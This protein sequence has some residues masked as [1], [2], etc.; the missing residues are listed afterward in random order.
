MNAILKDF[1][2]RVLANAIE[3]NMIAHSADLARS[4]LVELHRGDRLI[5]SI[6]T[7]N[8]PRFNRIL[9]A[10]FPQGDLEG[11]ITAALAPFRWRGYAGIWHTGPSTQPANLGERLEAYGLRLAAREPGMAADLQALP[12]RSKP[13]PGLVV[14]KIDG[15]DGL[16]DW[17]RI[18]AAAFGLPAE[19]VEA[20]F[21]VE[22]TLEA[23]PVPRRML[24]LGRL[25]G[26]TVAC[27]A[28]FVDSSVAGL[29]S[30]GTLPDVRGRGIG[31]AITIAALQEAV[32]M[33]YRVATLHA[34]LKG[35][36]IYRRLGFERYCTLSRYV[37]AG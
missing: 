31:T 16:R 25:Q 3:A 36:S 29:Y 13:V 1:T 8:Y 37:W 24:Y 9:Q 20:T 27:A 11:Q 2:P 30:V 23:A 15:L 10:Q 26:E 32:A 4:P 18:N 35:E 5:W 14:E 21:A 22:A 28:L 12:N 34:S 7:T 6:G 19:T 33:G 17:C